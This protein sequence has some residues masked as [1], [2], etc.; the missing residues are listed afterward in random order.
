MTSEA[1]KLSP[2]TSRTNTTTTTTKIWNYALSSVSILN[3]LFSVYFFNEKKMSNYNLFLFIL[4]INYTLAGAF[5]SIRP[6]VEG[7]RT[8]LFQSNISVRL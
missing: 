7:E 6:V 5:R 1:P 4:V 8:C 3:I 2:T